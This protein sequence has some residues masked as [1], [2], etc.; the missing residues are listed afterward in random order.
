MHK[1]VR[2]LD[3]PLKGQAFSRLVFSAV[4]VHYVINLVF[5]SPGCAPAI[6]IYPRAK[7]NNN[8]KLIFYE[9]ASNHPEVVFR[10]VL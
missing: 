2:V 9:E 3:N 4:M 6:C 1:F 10:R 8:N 5:V 7:Y